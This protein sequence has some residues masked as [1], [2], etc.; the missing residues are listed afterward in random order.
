LR[1]RV[2][3][4]LRAIVVRPLPTPDVVL[5]VEV[6]DDGLWDGIPVRIF[7]STPDGGDEVAPSQGLL[8]GHP[9]AAWSPAERA[10]L[11]PAVEDDT[12]SFGD[13]ETP[14]FIDW[15]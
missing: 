8:E 3:E 6:F 9:D 5:H 14:L 11:A 2:V 12:F 7:F 1:P 10:A 4:E 13:V 15:F